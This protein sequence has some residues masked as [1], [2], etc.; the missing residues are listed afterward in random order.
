LR[1]GSVRRH[2]VG[3]VLEKK[4]LEKV[5]KIF[6]DMMKDFEIFTLAISASHHHYL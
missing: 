4:I 3:N 1:L 5:K 6:K 2:A